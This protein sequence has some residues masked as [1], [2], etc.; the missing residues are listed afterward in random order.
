MS[1]T[2]HKKPTNIIYGVDDKLPLGALVPLVLQQIAT[3]SVDLM[4][5]V[6]IVAAIGGTTELAR[7]FVSLM[8]ITMGIGTIMQACNKGWVGSGYLCAHETNALLLPVSMLAAKNGGLHL[9][10]GMTV[11][12]GA[13]QVL[14]SKVIHKLRVL[15]PV[16]ITG[17]IITMLPISFIRYSFF[18]FVGDGRGSDSLEALIAFVT[19]AVIMVMFIWGKEWMRQYS[20]VAGIIV[21]FLASYFTRVLTE[22]H[23]QKIAAAPNIAFPNMSHVGWSFDLDLLVPFLLLAFCSSLKTLGNVSACQKVNDENWTKLD[24]KSIS[25]GLFA[26]G[27]GTMLGGFM[28]S[29]GQTTSSGSIGLAIA[30]GAVSRYIGYCVGAAFIVLA[31]LPKISTIFAIMPEPVMAAI[32][33]VEIVFIIPAGMQMCTSRMLDSRKFFVLG[34]AFTIG[35]AVEMFPGFESSLPVYLQ[36]LFKSSLSATALSAVLLN[37]LFRIGIAKHQ[38]TEMAPGAISSE[39]IA[40]FMEANGA[41]WGARREIINRASAVLNEFIESAAELGLAKGAVKVDVSFEEFNLDVD[42]YYEGTLMQFP[43][44]RP[45]EAELLADEAAFVK[46]SGY[47]IKQHVDWLKADSNNDNCHIRFHFDH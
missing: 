38:V 45:T 47:L 39:E 15:F 16:E 21:G 42:I 12:A 17:L 28:G 25:G 18:S 30:T 43:D 14:F 37:L 10:L 31:F 34:L 8:M 9:V 13:A 32:L 44:I 41:A 2:K 40:H 35:L 46:L 19:L 11:V 1:D 24:M 23:L 22:E 26:E 3:L 27:L 6:F 29:M 20:I 4:F 5:P 33:M 7:S 36:P